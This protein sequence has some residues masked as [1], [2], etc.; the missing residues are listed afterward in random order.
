M[1]GNILIVDDE[2][3]M[4]ELIET[5][6]RL[7][8]Y[9]SRW[10]TSA[11]AAFD[12]LQA[13][14]FDV[15]LTDVKM[16]GTSGLQLCEQ[17]VANRPDVPVVVMTAFGNLETA[18]ATIRV[19]AYDFV[20]KPIEMDLLAIVLNRAVRQRRLQQQV[21]MLSEA[22]ERATHFGDMIGESQ[23][24]QKLYDQLSRIADSEASVLITGESGTGKELVARS[25]HKQSRRRNS[26]FVAVNC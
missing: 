6:L 22:V 3:N 19:G 11:N 26:P 7:R 5:D 17:I 1:N 21:K 10:F 18:V 12:A 2:R 4:C 15:V 24:M 9:T 13:G 8:G 25:L 14:D 20:T 23:P 16:P